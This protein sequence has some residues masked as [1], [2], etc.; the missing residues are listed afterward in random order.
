ML[1][2]TGKK[3]I[4]WKIGETQSEL[5]NSGSFQ[6]T[7]ASSK[8]ILIPTNTKKTILPGEISEVNVLFQPSKNIGL[9][10]ILIS[11]FKYNIYAHIY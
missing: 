9:R 1:E 11:S 2:N 8:K 3:S 5:L 7:E 4:T 6:L 10:Y